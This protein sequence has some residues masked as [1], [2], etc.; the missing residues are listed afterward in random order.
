LLRLSKVGIKTP[1]VMAAALLTIDRIVTRAV[2]ALAAL[3][4]AAAA[5]SA[6]Y[7]VF[8]R[9]VLE[10][11]STWSEV[12]TRTLL[13]WMVYLGVAGAFRTGALVSVDV[14]Y[15]LSRGR[16][17]QAIEALITLSSLALL[18]IMLWY[19]A[20]MAYRVRFQNLAGLE[21]SIAWAYA[22]IPVGAAFA[23]LAVL[24]HHFDPQRR[25]LETAQ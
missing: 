13:I 23:M 16:A 7:Q 9:F 17:R 1:H 5:A 19:G 20:Q 18:G 6:F 8:T 24:A 2:M 25:E 11:P 21:I 3:L 22:A 15:T 4:L 14:L 10:Q 12:L